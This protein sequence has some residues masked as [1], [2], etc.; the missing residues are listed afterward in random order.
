MCTTRKHSESL[1]FIDLHVVGTIALSFMSRFCEC[2][3]TRCSQLLS[4]SYCCTSSENRMYYKAENKLRPK[5][6]A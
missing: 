3:P 4:V 1:Y 2:A 6:I 5:F